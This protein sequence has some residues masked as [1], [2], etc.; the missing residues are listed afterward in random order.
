MLEVLS[1]GTRRLALC[2]ADYVLTVT[3]LRWSWTGLADDA[4]A[5]DLPEFRPSDREAVREMM[6][7]R[8]LLASK[9]I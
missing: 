6:A 9:L 4:F 5:G 2:V 7:G 8:Y 3:A 1:F